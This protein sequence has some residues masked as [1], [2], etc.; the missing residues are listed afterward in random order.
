MK[1]KFFLPLEKIKKE[2][3]K[4][5]SIG[6]TPKKIAI[7]LAFGFIFGT[8]PFTISTL[9]CTIFA[10]IFKLNQPIIQLVNFIVF[11]FQIGLFIPYTKIGGVLLNQSV[12]IPNLYELKMLF[13]LP[14]KLFILKLGKILYLAFAGWLFSSPFIFFI[15]YFSSLFIIYKIKE[16]KRGV[17]I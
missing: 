10:L 11:P 7:T 17:Q 8:V 4:A 12:K 3:I 15:I 5:L 9:L 14:I 13:T 16:L 1:N 2:I 6:I